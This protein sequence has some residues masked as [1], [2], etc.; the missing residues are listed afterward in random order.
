PQRRTSL[1]RSR[2]SGVPLACKNTWFIAAAASKREEPSHTD[3]QTALL[4]HSRARAEPNATGNACSVP[5]L[6]L[7]AWLA[8]PTPGKLG[9]SVVSRRAKV[10]SSHVPPLAQAYAI[11]TYCSCEHGP[12]AS[13][14][15]ERNGK[16]AV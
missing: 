8:A 16:N 11:P 10:A 2:S 9:A 12:S 3:F 14:S 5:N 6:V 13:G 15:R 1:Q 4:Q 7:H